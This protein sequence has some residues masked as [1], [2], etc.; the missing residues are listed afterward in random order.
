M[1]PIPSTQQP[2]AATPKAEPLV[3]GSPKGARTRMGARNPLIRKQANTV[4]T[5]ADARPASAFLP[6][7]PAFERGLS[8]ELAFEHS[9][10]ER[11]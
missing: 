2:Q 6:F 1:V 8:S 9:H 10:R 3:W 11:R 5:L 4:D 7:R